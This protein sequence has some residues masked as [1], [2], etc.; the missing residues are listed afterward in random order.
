MPPAPM[1]ERAAAAARART[2]GSVAAL[3]PDG[4]RLR[5]RQAGP[6]RL[7]DRAEEVL[8]AHAVAGHPGPE[9]FRLTVDA[10]GQH[11]LRHPE[12]PVVT[13]GAR[14]C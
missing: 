12:M 6:L 13:W 14:P 10:A 1:G 5:V 7:W 3:A 8:A 2:T 4:D 11:H 9:A